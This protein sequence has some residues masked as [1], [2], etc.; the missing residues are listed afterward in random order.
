MFA[1]PDGLS[2]F[3]RCQLRVLVSVHPVPPWTLKLRNL[4]FLSLAGW[5]TC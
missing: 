3:W 2:T 1:P 4:S 5:T